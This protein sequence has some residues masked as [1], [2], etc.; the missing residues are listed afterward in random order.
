M[1]RLRDILIH[2]ISCAAFLAIPI[3]FAREEPG[4]AIASR[5]VQRDVLGYLITVGYF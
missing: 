1:N 3:F 4:L 5:G 2:V